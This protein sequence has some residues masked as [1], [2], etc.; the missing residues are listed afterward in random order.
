MARATDGY[1][2]IIKLASC[3]AQGLKADVFEATRRQRMCSAAVRARAC[4]EPIEGSSVT[5]CSPPVMVTPTV[6]PS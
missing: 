1:R 2:Q 3:L 5:V 4:P 6:R